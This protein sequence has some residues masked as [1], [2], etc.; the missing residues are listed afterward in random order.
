MVVCDGA[1]S[2]GGISG[3]SVVTVPDAGELSGLTGFIFGAQRGQVGQPVGGLEIGTLT[4]L[5]RA[6]SAAEVT[7][8]LEAAS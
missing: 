3:G 7:T 5:D 8:Y 6:L 2:R 1:S 4:I